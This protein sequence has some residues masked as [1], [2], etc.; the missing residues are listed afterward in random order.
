MDVFANFFQLRKPEG[1]RRYSVISTKV[2]PHTLKQIVVPET[3]L[4]LKLLVALGGIVGLLLIGV[5]AHAQVNPNATQETRNVLNY[6][7]S[8]EGTGKILSGQMEA[9]NNMTA[10]MD[11]IKTKTGK[12]PAI[13]GFD[14]MWDGDDTIAPAIDSWHNRRQLN[15]CW[16]PG[17]QY[18]DINGSNVYLDVVS[19]DYTHLE[20]VFDVH[21]TRNPYKPVAIT[22]NNVIPNPDEL[23]NRNIN[24]VWFLTWFGEWLAENTDSELNSVYNHPLTI[25]ADEMPNLKAVVQ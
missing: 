24:F 18:V 14:I 21:K 6:I 19:R 5:E 2:S 15:P 8:L 22:E 16:H 7:R 17:H 23:K 10:Q 20:V 1:K 11:K 4:L 13:V 25:T 12:F 3:C 9:G